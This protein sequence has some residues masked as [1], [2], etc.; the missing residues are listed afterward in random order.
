MEVHANQPL[1]RHTLLL[2]K[3]LQHDQIKILFEFNDKLL[4]NY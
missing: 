3:E 1:V 2:L 4:Q